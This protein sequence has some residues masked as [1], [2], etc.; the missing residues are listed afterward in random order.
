MTTSTVLTELLAERDVLLVDGATGTQLMAAGLEPG[1]A[2]ERL[3]LD[4]PETVHGLHE[5]YVNAG[6]DIVL[7]NTFGGSRLRLK[8]H[9]LDDRV[10][11]IN[12][13]AA[14]HARHVVDQLERRVLVAG[15]MGPTGELLAP[16]GALDPADA[17]DVF[18]EQAT[19]LAEGGAD[20]LW[21]ET[22]SSIEEIEAAID[23]CRSVS[24]LPIAVTLSF[25]TAGRTMMGVDGT[26]AGVRLRELGVA[27]MGA[28]CGNNLPDT[29]AALV[30][31]VAVAGGYSGDRQGQRRYPAVAR[32]RT[33]LLRLARGR[34]CSRPS[35]PHRRGFHHRRLLWQRTS[36][37]GLHAC[38][39]RRHHSGARR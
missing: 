13:E 20:L 5:S 6:S 1:D 31:M 33:R 39:A 11:E 9:K 24:D 19:G 32:R 36:P 34:R 26:T 8:L 16:L 7:T 17:A 4:H 12:R 23:G 38:G 29:E 28:N 25:D 30:Q 37:L 21:I 2:P 10:I 14:R 18:A 27:A 3:N 35:R 15:S 22:M